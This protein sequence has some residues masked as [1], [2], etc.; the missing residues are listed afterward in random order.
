M[1][2]RIA[3]LLSL[4]LLVSAFVPFSF[5]ES[6][7]NRVYDLKTFENGI[8]EGSNDLKLQDS[9]IDKALRDHKKDL[10]AANVVG[11]KITHTDEDEYK[12]YTITEAD[13]RS[14]LYNYHVSLTALKS[15]EHNKTK[16]ETQL[17]YDAK[18]DYYNYLLIQDKYEIYESNLALAKKDLEALKAKLDL[19]LITDT[20]YKN[21]EVAYFQAQLDFA[22]IKYKT[23]KLTRSINNKL[24]RDIKEEI[25]FQN[26][27]I[28]TTKY[29]IL[30]L[31]PVIEKALENNF[32][33]DSV[34]KELNNKELDLYLV[35]KYS[36][37]SGKIT[38]RTN[39][40]NDIEKLK[41]DLEDKKNEIELKIRSD[42]SDILSANDD[43]D[44]QLFNR[45]IAE[46]NSQIAKSRFDNGLISKIDYDKSVNSLE[47]AKL[48]Y[49]ESLLSYYLK[50]ESFKNYITDL[51]SNYSDEELLSPR[52]K[53]K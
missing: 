26:I 40:E 8:I 51:S 2:K 39:L 47:K 3:S 1:K 16:Q 37:T 5:A 17:K 34:Q 46:I 4:V 21:G 10:H 45:Q 32:E 38:Q 35:S 7:E 29:A 11:F 43:I 49:D 31:E 41:F 36:G 13:R 19:G 22:D 14:Y 42:Y 18:N 24:D 27:L 25:K 12:D 53:K 44:I 50:V 23:D 9:I 48:A 20:D 33:I 30:D 15:A 28:P 52:T 6:V